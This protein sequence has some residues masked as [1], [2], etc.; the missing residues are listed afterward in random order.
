[1]K[2]RTKIGLG[3]GI[4]AVLLSSGCK[5]TEP[6]KDASISSRNSEPARVGTMPDGFSN[7][8]AKCDGPNMV[9]VIFKGDN[10][11]GSID[12]VAN[13]PRCTGAQ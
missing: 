5:A 7:W 11:Y 8:A 12:V 4:I 1:M 10:T 3:V 9:Y 2:T 13:D 6:F